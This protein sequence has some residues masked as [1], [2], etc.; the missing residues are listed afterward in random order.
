MLRGRK[1]YAMGNAL[2]I[3]LR[4]GLIDAG[5]PLEYGTEL[6]DLV[7]EDGRVVGVKVVQRRRRAHDPRQ[8]RSDPG[9]RRVRE[10][11]RAARAVP[12]QAHQHRLDHGR[13]V[14]HRRRAP[15]RHGGGRGRG[16]DGRRLVGADDPAPPRPVVRAGRA[17]PARVDHRQLRRAAVHERGAAVRRGRARD[18]QGRGD[19]RPPRPGLD[20][21]R[22]AL[23]QPLSLRRA[24]ATAA[25]P[26]PLVQARHHQEGRLPRGA[27]GRDRGAGRRRSG[28][29]SSASTASPAPASTRTSTAAR[30]PT[31]STTP[32]RP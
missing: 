11:P 18:L 15:R 32:T 24:L 6:R 25:V 4:K 23:P 1:M 29:P 12:A 20:D 30:V 19:R 9:Q 21:H 22:P 31:T 2:A 13:G 7:V 26:G 14:Q 3:G 5:V 17:Q 10:E 27:G 28:R 8:A 16:P